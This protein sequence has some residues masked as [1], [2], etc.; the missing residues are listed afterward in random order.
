M[1]SSPTVRIRARVECFPPSDSFFKIS[2]LFLFSQSFYRFIDSRGNFNYRKIEV[3]ILQEK[4][5]YNIQRGIIV[6]KVR[7]L[8]VLFLDG[9][10]PVEKREEYL[11]EYIDELDMDIVGSTEKALEKVEDKDYEAVVVDYEKSDL[12]SLEKFLQ[13]F[14]SKAQDKPLLLL[15]EKKHEDKAFE[16]LE[17]GADSYLIK[18]G[19][20][21][22]LYR[23]LAE[24][25]SSHT[26]YYLMK[27]R[28]RF[29][30]SLIRLDLRNKTRI[31]QEYLSRID[32]SDLGEEQR[33]YLE[34][35]REVSESES[36]LVRKVR[37]IRELD[38]R[39]IKEVDLDSVIE[40]AIEKNK[41]RKFYQDCNISYQKSGCKIQGGY[42]LED[43]F[44]QLIDNSLRHS[45]CD[46]VNIRSESSEENCEV[47]IEDN[48]E[49]IPED[50]RD[51]IFD[52]SWSGRGKRGS[53]IGLYLVN[54][55]LNEYNGNIEV[56]DS[57]MGGACFDVTLQKA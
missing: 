9:S 2:P 3:L 16:A 44:N 4:P 30:Y 17:D 11:H 55:I 54:R 41:M 47:I 56:G 24:D 43:V 14:R 15:V 7:Y 8:K 28:E 23:K 12:E 46:E 13:E 18:R 34:V 22:S 5:R 31:I 36:D 20:R 32:E 49:G 1:P 29:L 37:K 40:A 57:E 42:L 33:E 19:D 45:C 35:A 27:K 26:S 39:E 38:V 51:N 21:E 52:R 50:I 10:E 53:G 6:N 48:G 25:I